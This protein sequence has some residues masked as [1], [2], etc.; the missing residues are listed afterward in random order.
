MDLP[1]RKQIRLRAHDASAPGA[2]FVTICA[3]DR[4]CLLSDIAVG[5]AISRP[6]FRAIVCLVGAGVLGGP[7]GMLCD[8]SRT[9]CK[10]ISGALEA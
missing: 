8:I 4:R 3:H 9:T 1:R 6:R 10:R 5:A 2:C 7:F